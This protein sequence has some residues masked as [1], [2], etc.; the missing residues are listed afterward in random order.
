M[1]NFTQNT[2]SFY[3]TFSKTQV[4]KNAPFN[5]LGNSINKSGHTVQ[6]SDVWADDIPFFAEKGTTDEVHSIFSA[7]AQTN[8]LV[9][10]GSKFYQRNTT[11]YTTDATFASL[12]SEKTESIMDWSIVDGEYQY[13]KVTGGLVDGSYLVNAAGKPVIKYHE[14][15]QLSILTA[16]NNANVTSNKLASRLKVGGTWGT[17]DK[18]KVPFMNGGQW[19]EQFVTVTD[20]YVNGEAATIY[21]PKVYATKTTEAPYEAGSIYFDFC[22]TGVIL[23]DGKSAANGQEVIT[24][25]EYVGDKLSTALGNISSEIEDIVSTTMEGVVASVGTTNAASTAGLSIKGTKTAPTVDITTG[26]V[27]S[28][29]AKL[30]TGGAVYNVTNALASR[31]SQLEGIQHF[32]V[33]VCEGTT[34]PAAPVENT[35]Y[36]VAEQGV[37][38]G[39]YIEYIAFKQGETVVTEKIGSTAIDLSGYTTNAEHTALAD[40]VTALDAATTGRVA[41][42]E[43]K[44]SS[45]E[46]QV[47]TL[48]TETIPAI[49]Q[50][51]TEARTYAEQKASAAQTA[52]TNAASQALTTARGEITQEIAAA[53]SAAESTAAS[54]LATAVEQIGK[55]IEAAKQA[56]ISSSTV[57][58]SQS[59][60]DTGI[61]V[62]PNGT[63]ANS[64]TIGVD[65]SIIATAASVTALSETITSNKSELEGKITAAQTAATTAASQALE[66]AKT[67]IKG[68]TD[69][70]DTRLQTA[71]GK[72]STLESQVATLTTGDNSVDKQIEAA[73][74][75]IKGQSLDQTGTLTGMF[76][77]A[78]AG[79]VGAGI[80]SITITDTGLS[81]AIAA[82]KSGAEQTAATALSTARGEITTE[83]STAVSALES[84]LTTGEDSL[85][86]KVAALETATGTTLPAAIEQAL[87]DAKAYS[88]S[89][90]TTSL[91]YVV[92]GDA[93]FLPTPSANT[94]GKIYLVASQNVPTIGDSAISG[95]YVEYMTRKVSE[96][97]YTW[98]KIGTTAADLNAYAKTS[99]VE[100]AV[101]AVQGEVDA[102][103]STHATD[104]AAL[105]ASIATKVGEV[106][107]FG[108]NDL[109]G[110]KAEVV[111]GKLVVS[112]QEI[113]NPGG[114]RCWNTNITKVVNNE[115]FIGDEKYATIETNKIK[116]GSYM[117]YSA[118]LSE[119]DSDLDSLT[120]GTW[121]FASCD[122][123]TFI[124][125][126][127]SL[128]EGYGM[129]DNCAI[130]ETFIGDL[131]SLTD[132]EFMFNSCYALTTFIS[133]LSSLTDGS[134]M[135]SH[136]KLSLESV[137]CIADTINTHNATIHIS[138]R[139][140]PAESERQAFV[141]ELSRIVDKGWELYTNPELLPLFDSEKYETGS[142]SV[143]PLDL[144]SES[145]TVYYVRKK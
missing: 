120:D 14:R 132:G 124:G 43:G 52:A 17:D 133:D 61:L 135:F 33:V 57:T 54:E 122:N 49:Q 74:T 4:N 59:T 69:A 8:D 73:A 45:L 25:F 105:E 7:Q 16:A 134:A 102:L 5:S 83:I 140:L 119:Y 116:D 27:T 88:D 103:K 42:V 111:D 107:W 26:T 48:T 12:W 78:T 41:V 67:E 130:L 104:K 108:E 46:S 6:A 131:S 136:T 24:C 40:R 90:H 10:V 137:E 2:L 19:V 138:W 58:L 144:D 30:V 109:F 118:S 100:A 93:E 96:T 23:W 66:T 18:E 11:P 115:A 92:L 99:E 9:K 76:S 36:L 29:E 95:S 127:S 37:A 97:E 13:T 64:F 75:A 44:V 22:A 72:V 39:T 145:Q 129:F 84:K 53:Q 80:T 55:D 65:K 71:E 28:G 141:D 56:A 142:F 20:K 128:T 63:A 125:D 123:T 106:Q 1:A 70:L 51:V 101:A 98:E 47:S 31:I 89:L 62:N 113:T 143:Q 85:S 79:S 60:T 34:L 114:D 86:A 15:A 87:D 91:D 35:I 117:F 82:A 112:E 77:V 94:L 32:S 21:A 3:H 126:L 68:T 50:S 121:M 139:T 81:T 110:S 38:E